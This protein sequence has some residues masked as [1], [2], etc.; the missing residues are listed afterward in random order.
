[1]SRE[2]R[3]Q[4]CGSSIREALAERF[5]SNHLSKEEGRSGEVAEQR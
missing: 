5:I 3:N 1:M 2:T 4:S